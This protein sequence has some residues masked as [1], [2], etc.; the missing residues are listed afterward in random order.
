[1]K[2]T[3]NVIPAGAL[4]SG[5]SSIS[6]E[7]G[8]CLVARFGGIRAQAN[9]Y[10]RDE[11]PTASTRRNE[12]ASRLLAAGAARSAGTRLTQTWIMLASLPM[13]AS[14]AAASP[15]R[16]R[17]DGQ[18]ARQDPGP[19]MGVQQLDHVVTLKGPDGP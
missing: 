16:M 17:P 6:T 14:L 5:S 15:P 11:R 4:T 10:G 9:T 1:M 19:S 2:A 12:L 18:P 7:A 8:S 13:S 3:T